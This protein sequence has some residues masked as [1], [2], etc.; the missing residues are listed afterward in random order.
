MK[1]IGITMLTLALL[2]GSGVIFGQKLKSGDLTVLKGQTTINLQ[3]DYSAMAVGKF[4]T[5]AEYL[6]K[7]TDDRNAKEPGTGDAWA[8]KW[9]TGKTEKYQPAFEEDFN[10]QAEGCGITGKTDPSAK[11]TLILHVTYVEQ[12]VETVVMGTA[13][14]ASINMQV[15]LIETSTPDK[16]LASIALDAVKAKTSHSTTVGGISVNKSA[17]DATLRIA[18]CFEAAGKQTGKFICKQIK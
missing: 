13:K 11:Y 15:D 7:G 9:N 3:Y 2:L 5:E 1:K 18:E 17:Y 10:K 14:A 8:A 12:G 16:V 6:K 4:A